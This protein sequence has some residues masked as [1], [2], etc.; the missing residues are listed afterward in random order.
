MTRRPNLHP[1]IFCSAVPRGSLRSDKKGATLRR[2]LISCCRLIVV[3]LAV[4]R[5]THQNAR[6]DGV[7]E[8]HFPTHCDDSRA[9]LCV[10]PVV[11]CCIQN[12]ISPSVTIFLHPARECDR[13]AAFFAND[14]LH[15]FSVGRTAT[16]LATFP[17]NIWLSGWRHLASG[18]G[19]GGAGEDIPEI[20]I[21]K[22]IAKP[23][24]LASHYT[25]SRSVTFLCETGGLRGL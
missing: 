2:L 9:C 16:F 21:V 4:Q 7:T 14:V 18:R 11:D 22:A 8:I 12:N 13:R 25:A 15:H 3:L 19:R 23:C 17:F 10:V 20:P 24:P 1:F 6:L 5:C